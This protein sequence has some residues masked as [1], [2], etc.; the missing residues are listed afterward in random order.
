M[1]PSRRC[2]ELFGPVSVRPFTII[3]Q[4]WT[5]DDDEIIAIDSGAMPSTPAAVP[6]NARQINIRYWVNLE[7]D[8]EL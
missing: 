3:V 2:A 4:N 8:I 5:S 1:S 7:I 6:A